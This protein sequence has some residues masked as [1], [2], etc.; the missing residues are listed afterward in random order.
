MSVGVVIVTHYGLGHE[1]LHALRLILP[2]APTFHAVAID[3]KQSVEVRQPTRLGSE[4]G[5]LE[6]QVVHAAS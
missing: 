4:G 3:P 1:F 6:T 5:K 2:D